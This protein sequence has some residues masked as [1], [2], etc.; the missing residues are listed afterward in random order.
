MEKYII[1]MYK[2]KPLKSKKSQFDPSFFLGYYC[3]KNLRFKVTEEKSEAI[4]Y[5]KKD[6]AEE[7]LKVINDCTFIRI[8][9]SKFTSVKGRIVQL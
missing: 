6:A 9:R 8:G 3:K 7:D 2:T 5:Y 4:I 1:E